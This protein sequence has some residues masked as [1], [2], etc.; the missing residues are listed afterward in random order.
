MGD[1]LD[2]DRI[3]SILLLVIPFTAWLFGFIQRFKD[4]H[5]VACLIR[6][7]F[8]FNII[9]I[10]DIVLTII[11]GCDVNLLRVINM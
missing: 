7:F 10:C 4:G 9:W 11:N 2:L 1:Y 5:I 8:G 3:I 6:L